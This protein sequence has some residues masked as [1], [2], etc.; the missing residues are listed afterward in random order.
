MVK[1]SFF[2]LFVFLFF[3][4]TYSQ[5]IVLSEEAR[6]SVLT[7]DTGNQLHTLFGHTG[8]RIADPK[9]GFDVVYNFGY[10]D[11]RTENFYLKFVKGN[12]Q[13]FVAVAGFDDFMTEYVYEQ[14]GVYEQV[15]N[16]DQL[17]K[18]HI[19]DDLNHRLQSDERFYTYKFIDRNCT[20]MV[21]EILNKNL[22]TKLNQNI[23][24][25]KRTNRSILYDYISGHQFYENLGI[26]IIF[27]H[28][29]DLQFYKTFLPLQLLE[30]IK[31]SKNNNQKLNSETKTLNIQSYEEEFSWWNNIYTYLLFFVLIIV[32]NNKKVFTGY[33]FVIG[34]L[35][36]FLLLV[37]FYSN[38]EETQLNYNAVLF[39]PFYIVVS[40]LF[41]RKKPNQKLVYFVAFMLL[42]YTLYIINKPFFLLFLPLVTTNGYI[43][44]RLMTNKN[45]L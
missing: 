41:M 34:V 42:I 1:K 6:I 23:K 45:N 8:L 25:A 3:Q 16:L 40:Y 29:V 28:K 30:S 27:G 12:L 32:L 4:S 17:Q 5:P 15:L 20:T 38:H 9:N 21:A 14:R 36:I 19:F 10:F 13:Y 35:G 37:G 7:C 11:F 31:I 18:Q 26:S 24:D 33:G 39:N 2:T 43:L 44:Y 22:T